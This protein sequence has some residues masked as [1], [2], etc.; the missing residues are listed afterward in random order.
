VAPIFR[1][2]ENMAIGEPSQLRGELVAL[3]DRGGDGHR[4]SVF[5]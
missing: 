2:P 4:K 1:Q 3:A 5:E